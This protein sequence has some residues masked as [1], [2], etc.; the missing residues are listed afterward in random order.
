MKTRQILIVFPLLLTLVA[1]SVSFRKDFPRRDAETMGANIPIISKDYLPALKDFSLVSSK[2][3]S[4]VSLWHK[5]LYMMQFLLW[6]HRPGA[7]SYSRNIV[8]PSAISLA[9]S[10]TVIRC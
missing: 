6:T 5:N 2:P 4:R 9:T 10:T 1:P 7:Y 3:K 8:L